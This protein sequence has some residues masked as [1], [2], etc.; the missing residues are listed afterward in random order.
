MNELS[1]TDLLA[2]AALTLAPG[3]T[4]AWR[5]IV[6]PIAPYRRRIE[7]L[8]AA[9]S[10]Y[11]VLSSLGRGHEGKR[12]LRQAEAGL[13]GRVE[14]NRQVRRHPTSIYLAL[15]AW[16]ALILGVACAFTRG[17]VIAWLEIALLFTSI[18]LGSLAW[19]GIRKL[20]A[21]ARPGTLRAYR[22]LCR[23]RRR[24]RAGSLPTDFA[25]ETVAHRQ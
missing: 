25:S 2:V 24:Q 3:I 13:L 23:S 6:G 9:E 5:F 15:S 1:L 10:A 14:F 12:D 17:P 20:M 19:R 8:A 22:D 7:H 4:F 21:V 11:Q 16:M 18:V